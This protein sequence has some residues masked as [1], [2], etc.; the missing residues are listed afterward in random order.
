[1]Q[2]FIVSI[3]DFAQRPV[4]SSMS[5]IF[6][7]NVSISDFAQRPVNPNKEKIWL[8]KF[9]LATL[10]NGL[11]TAA[12]KAKKHNSV[13]SISDFAQRPVNKFSD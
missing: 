6:P 11:S 2:G 13:V 5:L 7:H 10:L 9:Q 1:M 8:M 12:M 4:N 3:S